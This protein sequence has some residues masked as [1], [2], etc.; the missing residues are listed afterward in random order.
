MPC[1]E[2]E[3][4]RP[5]VS[6]EAF[7][8]PTAV[9]IGDVVISA[10]CLVGPGAALRGDIG[11][12]VMHEGSNVQDNCVVHCFPGK[13]VV[14]EPDGHVGHGAVLHGCV[15]RRN[16][17]VGMNAVVMDDAEVGESSFVGAMSFVKAGT[18]IPSRALYAGVPAR[19][20]RELSDK[21]IDWKSEGTGHYQ[22]LARRHLATA[23]EVEPL[24][25]VEPDR[26]T[27]PDLQ[28]KPKHEQG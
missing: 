5:V 21:E 10:G 24:A 27:V 28:Y 13:S 16:A 1:Y 12:I 26:R 2:F 23:R 20:I 18:V 19:M 4:I 15:I 25:E 14:I 8:H 17:L 6:P 7:V 3:G 11:R 22:H 9:L